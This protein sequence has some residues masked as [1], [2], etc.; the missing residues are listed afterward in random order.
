MV[1][2][3]CWLVLLASGL[4][5]VSCEEAAAD[6]CVSSSSAKPDRMLFQRG[7]APGQELHKT[8]EKINAKAS[9]RKQ[10]A[11]SESRAVPAA[12]PSIAQVVRPAAEAKE[13]APLPS[14]A[15][16]SLLASA[17][18][19]NHLYTKISSALEV[20]DIISIAVLAVVVLVAI[21]FVWGGSWQQLKEDPAGQLQNTALLA[22]QQAQ[23]QIQQ[24]Q[25]QNQRQRLAC[26]C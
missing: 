20:T 22:E 13:A 6:I 15:D 8:M 24:L 26:A 5:F 7:A 14:E 16:T 11:S 19:R 12:S 10:K 21:Y 4:C 3:S 23:A 25:A 2:S 1:L 9:E 18:A 17:T